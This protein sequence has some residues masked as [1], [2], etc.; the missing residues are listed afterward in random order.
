MVRAFVTSLRWMVQLIR[1]SSRCTVRQGLHKRVVQVED[2]HQRVNSTGAKSKGRLMS[3]GA[4]R[5][6]AVPRAPGWWF[7]TE[8]VAFAGDR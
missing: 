3:A 1:I 4:A 7:G 2:M 6:A 5:L 8:D